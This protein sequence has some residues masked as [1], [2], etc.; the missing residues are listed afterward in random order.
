MEEN[1]RKRYEQLRE[2]IGNFHDLLA[3]Q[4]GNLVV[5]IP[6]TIKEL[7]DLVNFMDMWLEE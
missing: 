6:L 2:K 5:G 3:D 4:E 1:A 7:T